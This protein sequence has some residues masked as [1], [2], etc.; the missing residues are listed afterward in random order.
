MKTLVFTACFFFLLIG[1]AS[2]QTST[3]NSEPKMPKGGSTIRGN[4][5][6]DDTEKPARRLIV[7]LMPGS[8]RTM[9]QKMAVTDGKGDFVFKNIPAG[10]YR[11]IASFP[12]RT[13]GS[14][15]SEIDLTKAIEVTT[16]GSS[17]HDVKIRAFR[18]GSITGR[19]TYPDGEPVIGAQVSVYRRDGNRWSYAAISTGG[20]ETNDRGI[21]RL[22]PLL[23][24]EY[25]VSAIE[26]G[27]VTQVVDDHTIQTTGNN[28]INPYFYQNGSNLKT[29]TIIQVEPGS[30][31]S[32]INLTLT[33][34]ATYEVSGTI[35]ANNK[36]VQGISLTLNSDDGG[37][38]G[39]TLTKPW[40]PV[41][42]SDNEGRWSFKGIPD[43]LYK[44]ELRSFGSEGERTSKYMSVQQQVTVVGDDVS[45]I[46]LNLTEGAKI[47]GTLTVEG[48]K[49]LP[50][51]YNF[52]I[53]SA[54]N[55]SAPSRYSRQTYSDGSFSITG[56][57]EGAIFLGLSVARGYF[58]KSLTYK[59]RDLRR[60]QLNVEAGQ[61]L[62]GVTAILSTDVG[63]LQGRV[64]SSQTT[65]AL[66]S[67]VLVLLP[68]DETLWIGRHVLV[69]GVT[70][71]DGNFKVSGAPGD[72]RIAVIPSDPRRFDSFET[73]KD[74]ARKAQRV[75]MNTTPQ[76]LVEIAVP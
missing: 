75:S 11:I 65:K 10:S 58:V 64:V 21:F 25:A 13:N 31:V 59:G 69:T 38:G 41:V 3:V 6:Y 16:D 40:G 14:P 76:E 47:S 72:Y 62:T 2:A 48:G 22:Y 51:Y 19:I 66:P 27:M 29:A 54:S 9:S 52:N 68:V 67:T 5:I 63:S 26:Q 18:G 43:G 70:D 20:A 15:V 74:L 56:I 4:A 36:P 33:E 28:S 55:S 53:E 30:E 73:L 60:Q 8:G 45:G 1:G 44:I 57:A 34:R 35:T 46:V 32:N 7:M 24:G 49:P 39:P 37:L 12:G 71:I 42:T 17:S 23:A 61:E 50:Q